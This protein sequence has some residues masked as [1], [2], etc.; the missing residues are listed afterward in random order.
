MN[1]RLIRMSLA[2]LAGLSVAS[3]S[4][5]SAFVADGLPEWAGGLPRG[6]P[7]R[8]GAPGYDAYL[9]SISGD[10]PVK[11]AS[12]PAQQPS[13]PRKSRDPVDDPIH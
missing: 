5:T 7:P 8:P 9:K 4:S 6:T 11:A 10:D 12:E 13:P 2:V 3:C 1:A